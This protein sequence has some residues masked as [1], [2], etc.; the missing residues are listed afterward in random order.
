[1]YIKPGEKMEILNLI[2]DAR[3]VRR[4]NEAK[5][6]SVE[7]LENIA[8]AARIVPSTA[9][10]QRLR[11]VLINDDRCKRVFD[12]L[13][14]ARALKPK[15]D[16]PAEGERPSAYIII[17]TDKELDTNLAIDIGIAAEAM[18]LAAKENGLGCCM[19]R[20]FNVDR[21]SEILGKEPYGPVR[22]MSFGE[23]AESV[24]IKD[25]EKRENTDDL[26]YYRDGEDRHCVPKISL[27]TF[28]IGR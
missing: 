23:P 12:E 2:R 17:M 20:S 25:V 19:F 6:V 9:N 3:S 14:F 28:I 10:M 18:M 1:M 7:E 26:R 11:L 22:V 27:D 16:G 24:I 21:L 8:A 13:S 4:Y 5:K 15:W